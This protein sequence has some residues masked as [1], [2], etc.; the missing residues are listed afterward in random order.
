MNLTGWEMFGLDAMQQAALQAIINYIEAQWAQGNPNFP[1]IPHWMFQPFSKYEA[2]DIL[3]SLKHSWTFGTPPKGDLMFRGW[4]DGPATALATSLPQGI[5]GSGGGP[6]LTVTNPSGL[7]RWVAARN[8]RA[9]VITCLG[10]SITWGVGSDGNSGETFPYNLAQQ[11]VYRTNSWPAHLRTK[12]SGAFGFTP[13]QNFIGFQ[14]GWGFPFTISGASASATT[15]PFGQ[16]ATSS[17]GGYAVPNG[18][19]ITL[20]AATMG[21]W[22]TIDVYYWGTGS[23]VSSPCAPSVTIDSVPQTIPLGVQAGVLNVMTFTVSS[24]QHAVVLTGTQPTLTSYI[25]AV[26]V[27]NG[28]SGIVVNRLAAPGA[29][30][31]DLAGA[32]AAAIRDRVLRS[33]IMPGITDVLILSLGTNDQAAQVPIVDYKADLQE[34]I[35]MQVAGGGC[36]LL[37]GEPAAAAPVGVLTET[38]YRDAM[39]DLAELNQHV[40]YC[41]IRQAFG[42]HA[43]GFARGFY[44][45]ESTV[46]PSNAGAEYMALA[47]AQVLQTG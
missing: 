20:D 27:R 42:T 34:V 31:N 26:N 30:A 9:A 28:D 11:A 46:H 22:T 32:S 21:S 8:S 13:A 12:L 16:F 4:Q 25:W 37:L 40:A 15:G 33:S 39:Q 14:P 36:V 29:T 38:D 10:D 18:A 44:A 6:L 3:A 19:S 5:L 24:G 43:E 35:D 47:V 41:D 1:E 45:S 17:R 7:S 23:G 2:E